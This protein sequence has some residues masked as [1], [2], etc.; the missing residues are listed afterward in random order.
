ML[1][2]VVANLLMSH[3]FTQ[4]ISNVSQSEFKQF[5]PTETGL[6][7]YITFMKAKL[8]HYKFKFSKHVTMI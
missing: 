1:E 3:I 8:L 7:K 6:L 4:D 5:P 2:P